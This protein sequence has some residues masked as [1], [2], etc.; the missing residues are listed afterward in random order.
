MEDPRVFV[1][2]FDSR[3]ALLPNLVRLCTAHDNLLDYMNIKRDNVERVTVNEPEG[4]LE[5]KNALAEKA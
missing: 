4:Y 5:A 1:E 3:N 2:V